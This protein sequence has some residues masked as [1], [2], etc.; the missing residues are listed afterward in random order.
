MRGG[1][2]VAILKLSPA[3]KDY[4]WGGV[5][6]KREYHKAFSGERLAETW[7]LSCHPDGPS[8]I[9][10]GPYGGK[11][12]GDYITA[13]G[14]RVLGSNCQIFE[15]F[16]ILIKLIDAKENLSI[17]VHPNNTEALETE[18]QYG[19][20]ELWYILETEPGAF[21]YL[22]FREPLGREE[23][24]RRIEDGTLPEVL[25]AVPVRP[26]D[27]FYI[28]AGT[29]H[30]IG[31]GILLAEIQQNSNVTYRVFDYGRKGPD[32]APRAL[33]VE[34][35]LAV[36]HRVPP[37]TDYNF[38]GHL[39]RTPYFTA[40]AVRGPYRGESDDESF[41]SVLVTGGAGELACGAERRPCRKG[42]SFFLPAES[43]P[44]SL[45]GGVR[46]LVTQVGTI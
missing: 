23:F 46:A 1:G 42:D 39:A 8:R 20:S 17:Q 34:Q 11:T 21:L 22:G 4:L 24:R 37:R 30:A 40:D 45:T 9:D 32:G 35:A 13:E 16:P 28:P 12:L 15:D 43:G 29:L 44:F 19:K 41:T 31:K 38:G 26:G 18:G 3:C 27:V 6:L 2:G 33:H 5:R 25:N 14:R 36:T 7:E 10:G